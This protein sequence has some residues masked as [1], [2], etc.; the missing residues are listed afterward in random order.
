LRRRRDWWLSLFI[1]FFLI[2]SITI[3]VAVIVSF[4]VKE[5]EKDQANIQKRHFA[6][7]TK[8]ITCISAIICYLSHNCMMKKRH[9]QKTNAMIVIEIKK[10]ENNSNK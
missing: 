6:A 4:K 3:I 1:S 8:Q 10:I 5:I 7:V 9:K 2:I